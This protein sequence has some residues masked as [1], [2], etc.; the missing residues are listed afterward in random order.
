MDDEELNDCLDD[1]DLQYELCEHIFEDLVPR[2]LEY[3]L[4]VP[5]EGGDDF[6]GLGSP[7]IEECE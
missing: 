7:E 3:Y 2:S 6:M 4:N 5:R 1:L